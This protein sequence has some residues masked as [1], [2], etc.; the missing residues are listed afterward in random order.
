MAGQW[1]VSPSARLRVR[2]GSQASRIVYGVAPVIG[3]GVN[4][5]P[6]EKSA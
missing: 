4:V 2:Q 1:S 3:I 5:N 6:D